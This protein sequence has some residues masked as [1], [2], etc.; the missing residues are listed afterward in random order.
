LLSDELA[1]HPD[2]WVVL[3]PVVDTPKFNHTDQIDAFVPVKITEV[4]ESGS[5]KY[6][7]GTILTMEEAA[8][9]L[10]GGGKMGA[11]APPKLVQ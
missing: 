7:K 8:S 3:L 1:L 10:P 6:V 2:G 9:A 11:L 5:P 4:K